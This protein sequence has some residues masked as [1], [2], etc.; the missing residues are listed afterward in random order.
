M[1]LSFDVDRGPGEKAAF[2]LIVLLVDETIEAEFRTIFTLD[3]V[4]LFHSRIESAP[5]VTHSTL[6]RMKE[7]L[8]DAAAFLPANRPLDAIGYACTSGATVI[9]SDAVE[10]AVRKAHPQA[11]VTD[12]ARAVMAALKHMNVTRLGIVSPYVEEVS[13]AICDLLRQN[14]LETLAAGS[15]GQAEEA[16]VARISL[17]S[18]E[19]AICT[20][21]S[22]PQVEAVFASCTNLRTFPVIERSERRLGK[23]VIS[24]NQ[25]LAWHMMVLAGLPSGGAG[26]GRLFND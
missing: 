6:M 4:S 20:V 13:G 26:P 9:G 25:A 16:V 10:A 21:G 8:T 1:K 19:E 15:F 2:G 23:P 3:G 11:S 22:D 7:R 12:P 5:E 14:G 24:S 17:K 18:V